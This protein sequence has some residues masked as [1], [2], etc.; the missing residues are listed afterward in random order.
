MTTPVTNPFKINDYVIF[1]DIRKLPLQRSD[2]P[3][4]TNTEVTVKGVVVSVHGD[5]LS[6]DISNTI[7]YSAKK[8]Y[9][10]TFDV[11]YQFC[12]LDAEEA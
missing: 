11:N 10:K 3:G 9:P 4:E 2:K 12:E 1:K 7:P 5:K 8:Y 6:I